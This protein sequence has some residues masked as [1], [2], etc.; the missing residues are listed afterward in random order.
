MSILGRST[1]PRISNCKTSNLTY[2]AKSRMLRLILGYACSGSDLPNWAKDAGLGWGGCPPCTKEIGPS[3]SMQELSPSMRE[4]ILSLSTFLVA[5]YLEYVNKCLQYCS[6]VWKGSIQYISGP[7]TILLARNN[8]ARSNVW[9]GSS[10]PFHWVQ[11]T[12][13]RSLEL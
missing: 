9:V 11:G 8:Q 12:C 2:V 10:I 3:L 4:P 5:S 13:G 6:N 1:L 7:R